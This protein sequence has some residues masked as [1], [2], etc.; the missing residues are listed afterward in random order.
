MLN[1]VSTSM[2]EKS[3][4]LSTQVFASQVNYDPLDPVDLFEHQTAATI[5]IGAEV[6]VS[7]GCEQN[8]KIERSVITGLN[9]V[10]FIISSEY[11]VD[12]YID[13][14]RKQPC[15]LENCEQAI[16]YEIDVRFIVYLVVGIGFGLG[17]GTG[18]A[19]FRTRKSNRIQSYTTRCICCDQEAE[20]SP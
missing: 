1:Q 10:G 17:W 16:Q 13:R 3:Q 6:H 7:F 15:T 12:A 18:T 9:Q 11:E 20:I 8:P 4:A 2:P 5:G 14:I 19:G